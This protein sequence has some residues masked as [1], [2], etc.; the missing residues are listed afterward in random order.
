MEN[1]L[2]YDNIIG[3]FTCLRYIVL[4]CYILYKVHKKE[5]DVEYES[6]MKIIYGFIKSLIAF[7]FR[8]GV[9]IGVYFATSALMDNIAIWLPNIFSFNSNEN[10]YC[11]ST[12]QTSIYSM[13]LISFIPNAIIGHYFQ[14]KYYYDAKIIIKIIFIISMIITTVLLFYVK[15]YVVYNIGWIRFINVNMK[16]LHNYSVIIAC[17]TPP[18]VD[19][20]QATILT[21]KDN[22]NTEKNNLPLYC[23]INPKE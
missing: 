1:K 5:R 17:L 6:N 2:C 7:G 8:E 19:L 11:K 20:I 12:V 10:E 18:I 21:I 4:L 15:M 3:E 14:Q 23:E 22:H 16:L 9:A 13:E